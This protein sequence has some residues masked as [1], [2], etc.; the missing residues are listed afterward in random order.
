MRGKTHPR[1]E[2]GTSGFIQ[3]VEQHGGHPALAVVVVG[4]HPRPVVAVGNAAFAN[5]KPQQPRTALDGNGNLGVV[6]SGGARHH[7]RNR[8]GHARR[9]HHP[10]AAQAAVGSGKLVSPG[11]DHA[12]SVGRLQSEPLQA[13]HH[14]IIT[15]GQ[16]VFGQ[17]QGDVA[18]I[19]SCHALGREAGGPL[20]FLAH[21]GTIFRLAAGQQR[22]RIQRTDDR[23]GMIGRLSDAFGQHRA[24]LFEDA[25]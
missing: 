19:P 15:G 9:I 21:N 23:V 25:L 12:L 10:V 2:P 7:E 14:R 8:Q 1:K 4:L 11:A 20:R 18:V 17:K 24:A 13:G 22:E 16:F 5:I 3:Q 6:D